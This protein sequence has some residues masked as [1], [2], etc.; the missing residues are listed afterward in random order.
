VAVAST[1]AM[2]A[3]PVKTLALPEFT[4]M[5]RTAPPARHSRHHKTGA[6]AVSDRVKTPA[7]VLPGASSASIRSSRPA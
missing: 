6:P 5:A 1:A 2:P 3:R 7:T 4:T